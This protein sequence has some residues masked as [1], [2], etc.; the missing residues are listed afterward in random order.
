MEST[1]EQATGMTSGGE[2]AEAIE[3][4]QTETPVIEGM[5]QQ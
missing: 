4:A 5:P 3:Q 2:A 1:D